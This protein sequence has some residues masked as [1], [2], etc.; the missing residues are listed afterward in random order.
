M[1]SATVLYMW[2]DI[3]AWL[4]VSGRIGVGM[5]R[6]AI[7]RSVGRFDLSNGLDSA[8]YKN[9]PLHVLVLDRYTTIIIM[10]ILHVSRRIVRVIDK[11]ITL[12]PYVLHFGPHR[13]Y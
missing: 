13:T 12:L 10:P 8:P 7:G 3:V 1:I 9:T 4:H 5:N 11:C 2:V 6:S